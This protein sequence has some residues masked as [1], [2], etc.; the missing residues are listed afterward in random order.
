MLFL[1]SDFKEDMGLEWCILC[2][3]RRLDYMTS[4]G[5]LELRFEDLSIVS[6]FR[7]EK[8]MTFRLFLN[9]LSLRR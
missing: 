8:T 9:I 1:S 3:G 7:M 5:S 4:K 2:S 6:G